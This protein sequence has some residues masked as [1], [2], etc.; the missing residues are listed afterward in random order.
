[1]F[2]ISVRMDESILYL[3][4][5]AYNKLNFLFLKEYLLELYSNEL[6]QL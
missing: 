4:S 5:L 6:S 3:S 1:M 2:L